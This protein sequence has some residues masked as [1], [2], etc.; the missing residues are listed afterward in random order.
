MKFG[1]DRDAPYSISWSPYGPVHTIKM[2]DGRLVCCRRNPAT[3]KYCAEDG[4]P[5]VAPD[6]INAMITRLRDNWDKRWAESHRHPHTV[7]DNEIWDGDGLHIVALGDDPRDRTVLVSFGE[8]DAA[9]AAISALVHVH[10]EMVGQ[11]D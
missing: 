2:L 9:S 1:G 10:N 4:V 8:N 5:P 11:G 7:A 6:P 3:C